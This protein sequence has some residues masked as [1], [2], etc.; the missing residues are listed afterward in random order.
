MIRKVMLI[1]NFTDDKWQ[2]SSLSIKRHRPDKFVDN[3]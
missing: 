2:H 1:H 3:G